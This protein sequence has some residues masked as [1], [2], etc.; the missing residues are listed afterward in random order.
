[1]KIIQEKN[2]ENYKI[3]HY[4]YS[5]T[6]EDPYSGFAFECNDMGVIDELKLNSSARRNLENCRNGTYDVVDQGVRKIEWNY[7]VPRVGLCDNCEKEITLDRYTN[8]CHDC[9]IDYDMSGNQLSPRDCWGEE[10]GEHW[11]DCYQ[12]FYQN[13]IKE[14]KMNIISDTINYVKNAIS[15]PVIEYFPD[16]S[17]DIV[18]AYLRPCGWDGAGW[19]FW[20]TQLAKMYGPYKSEK[21]V[22]KAYRSF[23]NADQ[24]ESKTQARKTSGRC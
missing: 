3:Y 14:N 13:S 1:M 24:K 8:T 18:N 12:N 4:H 19:Y 17:M 7:L 22:F 2:K 5:W 21:E 10:T 16:S 6:E 23:C 9:C 11:T 20:D 15:V